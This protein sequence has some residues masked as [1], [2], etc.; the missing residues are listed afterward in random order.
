[1]LSIEWLDPVPFP[2]LEEPPLNSFVP[3]KRST[4]MRSRP[5]IIDMRPMLDNPFSP[6]C[7]RVGIIQ[8]I[9]SWAVG[10]VRSLV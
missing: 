1:L 8:K 2:P 7:S 4:A 10:G 3:Y 6:Q 9:G 5:S